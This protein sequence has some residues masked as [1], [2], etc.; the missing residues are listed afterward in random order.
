MPSKVLTDAQV[1][2]VR[3]SF[4]T[5]KY[6][7]TQLALKFNVSQNGISKIVNRQRRA[8]VR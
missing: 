3:K 8:D 7:Q 5:G 4:K 2:T 6:T 1:R